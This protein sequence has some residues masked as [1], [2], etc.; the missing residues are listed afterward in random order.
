MPGYFEEI[1]VGRVVNLGA[2]AL[3][4]TAVEAFAEAFAPGWDLSFGIP[5]AM[6]SIEHRPIEPC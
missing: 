2:T 5:D 6:L 1:E 4:P 3:S